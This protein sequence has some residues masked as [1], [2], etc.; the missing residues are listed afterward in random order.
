MQSNNKNFWKE[1][2]MRFLVSC[3]GKEKR[4]PAESTRILSV[5]VYYSCSMFHCISSGGVYCCVF[6]VEILLKRYCDVQ[7]HVTSYLVLLLLLLLHISTLWK[8]IRH[9]LVRLN[10]DIWLQVNLI[11]PSTQHIHNPKYNKH[12]DTLNANNDRP[13][14]RNIGLTSSEHIH[15]ILD[16]ASDYSQSHLARECKAVMIMQNYAIWDHQHDGQHHATILR[17]T[18]HYIIRRHRPAPATYGQIVSR[19]KI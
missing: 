11:G 6:C 8:S 9:F 16:A 12:I 3:R 14:W 19:Q 1:Y 13:I 5:P 10:L 4:S 15:H 17:P 18:V 7:W 2:Q